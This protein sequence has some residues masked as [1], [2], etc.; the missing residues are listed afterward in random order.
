[1]GWETPWYS[2]QARPQS[3]R[4]FAL[5]ATDRI[6]RDPAR[7]R[8]DR[9]HIRSNRACIR[10]YRGARIRNYRK[11]R[12]RSKRA[13]IRN[14]SRVRI[15]N[16]IVET[17]LASRSPA[18]ASAV[19][20]LM[21]A[22]SKRRPERRHPRS[23]NASIRPCDGRGRGLCRFVEL[24]PGPAWWCQG[25][26]SVLARRRHLTCR[27]RWGIISVDGRWA[28]YAVRARSASCE[29]PE[30]RFGRRRSRR[31]KTATRGDGPRARAT[32]TLFRGLERP[33]FSRHEI[34]E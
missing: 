22:T 11:G 29:A 3:A 8:R 7:I 15:R 33:W 32:T 12:I 34:R 5:R 13:C 31:V 4:G 2:A 10:N 19:Q 28:K 1:M 26:S 25:R 17:K 16:Y 20:T 14:Y 18:G 27:R 24:A 21:P 23:L 6:S 30:R 9:A